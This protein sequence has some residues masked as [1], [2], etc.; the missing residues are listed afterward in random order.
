[1]EEVEVVFLNQQDYNYGPLPAGYQM[2]LS[3]DCQNIFMRQ[4]LS[5]TKCPECLPIWRRKKMV[6]VR[7]MNKRTKNEGK[8]K[9]KNYK[10]LKYFTPVEQVEVQKIKAIED[11]VIHVGVEEAEQE[12]YVAMK[13]GTMSGNNKTYI[14]INVADHPA[15]DRLRFLK[16]IS[17]LR[18][19]LSKE[20]WHIT[21]KY[22]MNKAQKDHDYL[23]VKDKKALGRAKRCFYC[24]KPHF[25]KKYCS[26]KCRMA[27]QDNI[28]KIVFPKNE[29]GLP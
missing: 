4:G 3:D 16:E 1:M 9:V 7:K 25:N 17:D 23:S 10:I 19:E 18:S 12:Y 6:G 26:D 8:K 15:E 20:E 5:H 21:A 13:Y 28:K 14:H 2:C 24:N 27:G 29:Y 11:R 22:I